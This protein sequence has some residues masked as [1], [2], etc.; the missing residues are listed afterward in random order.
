TRKMALQLSNGPTM[1]MGIAKRLLNQ[2]YESDFD[3]LL[4]LENSHQAL[5]RLTEDHREGVKAFFEKR[6]PEFKG[7]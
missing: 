6:K 4:R 2:S 3:T 1:A 7:R 5:L